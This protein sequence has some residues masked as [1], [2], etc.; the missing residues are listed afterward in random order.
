MLS[1]LISNSFK[2]EIKYGKIGK[3]I[4][5]KLFNISNPS[6]VIVAVSLQLKTGF[7]DLC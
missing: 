6:A 7:V 1:Y 3:L 5:K 2:P 4:S